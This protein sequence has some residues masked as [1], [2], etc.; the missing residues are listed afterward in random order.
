MAVRP[1]SRDLNT[2]APNVRLAVALQNTP[3]RNTRAWYFLVTI[4]SPLPARGSIQRTSNN[5][6]RAVKAL[7]DED[8]AEQV[9]LLK[10]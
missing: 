8:M 7:N 2:P 9:Q 10:T 4:N 6:D 5:F 3:L 1:P